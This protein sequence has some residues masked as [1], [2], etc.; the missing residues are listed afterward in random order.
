MEIFFVFEEIWHHHLSFIQVLFFCGSTFKQKPE[1][2]EREII[3]GVLT[4]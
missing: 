4:K 1:Q 3:P 2:E